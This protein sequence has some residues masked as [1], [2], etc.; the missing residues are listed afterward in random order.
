M[1]PVKSPEKPSAPD[2]WNKD[3]G[4]SQYEADELPPGWTVETKTREAGSRNKVDRRYTDPVTGYIFRSLRDTQR[5][6]RTGKIGRLAIKPKNKQPETR[7]ATRQS[8]IK[9]D[10]PPPSPPDTR[11]NR[12]AARALLVNS[13]TK[14]ENN[15]KTDRGKTT[16]KHD[17]NADMDYKDTKMWAATLPPREDQ[18]PVV[19]VEKQEMPV[20]NPT[21][22]N[23]IKFSMSDLWTDLGID[24]AKPENPSPAP[25][26]LPLKELWTD[27]CIEFAVKTLM[28]A[29]PGRGPHDFYLPD[30]QQHDL[31]FENGG[32]KNQG[33]FRL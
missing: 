6:I 24:F 23:P 4:L 5:Y 10:S 30:K 25:L 8:G 7:R 32:L 13:A 26:T 16:H 19:D 3:K 20:A 31:T 11:S 14:K 17:E 33:C 22:S 29:I 9:I 27:P 21:V 18:Q 28:G 1:S 15:N 12:Q 2:T